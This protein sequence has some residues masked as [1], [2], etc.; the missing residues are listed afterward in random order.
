MSSHD[1]ETEAA[2]LA[3]AEKL[4]SDEGIQLIR[5]CGKSGFFKVEQSSY[6][7]YTYT[8]R[9]ED[10]R[11]SLGSFST[12]AE[13]AL[14]YARLLGPAGCIR[15]AQKAS[16]HKPR[17]AKRELNSDSTF[18][19]PCIPTVA[20]FSS[21][22]LEALA[23]EAT[24]IDDSDAEDDEADIPTQ[25]VSVSSIAAHTVVRAKS[26]R[27]DEYVVRLSGCDNTITLPMPPDA[28]KGRN[29]TVKLSYEV[30]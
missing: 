12:A 24:A 15:A 1:E 28:R 26:M 16:K 25:E 9:S 11:T 14:C 22:K 17:L 21:P 7:P 30:E 13:A 18:G 8:V 29:I 10:R 6:T 4:A 5:G 2:A 23:V 3:K 27:T 19:Q 20:S